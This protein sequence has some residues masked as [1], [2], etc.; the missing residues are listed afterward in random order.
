MLHHVVG[1][2][3]IQEQEKKKLTKQPKMMLLLYF[4]AAAVSSQQPL[5]VATKQE[6]ERKERPLM[7]AEDQTLQRVN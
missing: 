5:G 4:A 1:R 2:D 6:A 7:C 3:I